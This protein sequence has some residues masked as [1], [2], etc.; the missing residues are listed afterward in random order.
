MDGQWVQKQDLPP[1][2]PDERTPSPPPQ[3]DSLSSLLHDG[4]TKLWDLR[5]FVVIILMLWI[6]V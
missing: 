6:H 4:L 5:A 1:T 3:R 2:V